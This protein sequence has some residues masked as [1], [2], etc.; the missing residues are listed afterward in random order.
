MITQC[1]CEVFGAVRFHNVILKKM[2]HEFYTAFCLSKI[3]YILYKY[4]KKCRSSHLL[5]CF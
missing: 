4:I 5:K 3:S 1:S 2:F